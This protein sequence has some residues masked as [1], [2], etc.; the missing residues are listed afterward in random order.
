MKVL[1]TYASKHGSTRGIA[2]AIGRRLSERGMDADVRSVD[3]VRELEPYDA[4]VVGSAVYFGAWRKDALTFLDRHGDALRRMPVW[5]FSSGPTG[6][7]GEPVEQKDV[8]LLA[9][10]K[11]RLEA[12]GARDHRLFRGAADPKELSF[13]ERA[14]LKM[15]KMPMGDFRD[16]DDIAGWADGIAD[17]MVRDRA[18]R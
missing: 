13:I 15:A 17:R 16:W 9:K 3:E 10:T 14:P 18:G 2:E 11:D 7:A 4:V 1:V 6:P 5:L 8:G 12:L